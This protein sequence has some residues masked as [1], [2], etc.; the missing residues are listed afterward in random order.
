MKVNIFLIIISLF[1]FSSGAIETKN[2]RLKGIDKITGRSF[3]VQGKVEK[4]MYYGPLSMTVRV[5][6]KAPLEEKPESVAFIEIHENGKLIFSSW[7]FAS[8]PSLS[9]LDHPIFYISIDSCEN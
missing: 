8:T 3:L 4:P 9:S 1:A 6:H 7:M 5:C 2:V